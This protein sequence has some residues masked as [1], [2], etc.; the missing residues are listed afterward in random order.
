MGTLHLHMH[1]HR[2]RYIDVS[3]FSLL[4]VVWPGLVKGV[5]SRWS[6]LAFRFTQCISNTSNTCA[7]HHRPPLAPLVAFRAYGLCG[8]SCILYPLP[9]QSIAAPDSTR[10]TDTSGTHWRLSPH[11][12][13]PCP[14]RPR[15]HPHLS[16]SHHIISC[17]GD[18]PCH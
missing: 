8:I 3:L 11:S 17:A 9:S 12:A 7:M 18:L 2:Y 13:G 14:H 4:S 10:V 1:L 5:R 16:V 15:A 6:L